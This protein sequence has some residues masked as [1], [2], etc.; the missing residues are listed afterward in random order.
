MANDF[1]GRVNE[2][3][4]LNEHV[5]IFFYF[6]FA[7]MNT[8]TTQRY[9]LYWKRETISIEIEID[10]FSYNFVKKN[11]I[12]SAVKGIKGVKDMRKREGKILK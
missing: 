4:Y 12:K 3:A 2:W 11:R 1:N 9:K 7:N 5:R 10:R 6:Y 8:D